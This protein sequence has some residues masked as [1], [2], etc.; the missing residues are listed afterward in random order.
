MKG[1]KRP[2]DSPAE[3]QDSQ[4]PRHT[5]P[6]C[7][8]LGTV[9]GVPLIRDTILA[10]LSYSD[11]VFAIFCLVQVGCI[12]KP[13]AKEIFESWCHN[14]DTLPQVRADSAWRTHVYNVL[15][16]LG[17]DF[18]HQDTD[19]ELRE[20]L[21]PFE[22]T[23][24]YMPADCMS[25]CREVYQNLKNRS[26]VEE[27]LGPVQGRLGKVTYVEKHN[28]VQALLDDPDRRCSKKRCQDLF[29]VSDK[30]LKPLEYTY[31]RNIYHVAK[32]PMHMYKLLEVAKVSMKKY[33]SWD[34][35]KAEMEK[36][37]IRAKGRRAKLEEKHAR[38]KIARREEL[39]PLLRERGLEDFIDN[40]PHYLN[41]ARRNDDKA[42]KEVSALDEWRFFSTE[43]TE[44][45]EWEYFPY[46]RRLALFFWVRKHMNTLE[47]DL[48]AFTFPPSLVEKARVEQ[49]HVRRQQMLSPRHQEEALLNMVLEAGSPYVS[50]NGYY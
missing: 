6:P 2:R 14:G 18:L 28:V 13:E 4:P 1:R 45:P 12:S 16:N 43:T 20:R 34:G 10:C 32:Y 42:A 49:R 38:D 37:Q 44:F 15:H 33:G 3:E 29:L 23:L 17:V 11:R 26:R 40:C 22:K 8:S 39:M 41:L 21:K 25:I 47:D 9:F 5:S 7:V 30:D 50:Y 19:E 48:Q 35:L 27:V 24:E 46:S 31:E 36:R